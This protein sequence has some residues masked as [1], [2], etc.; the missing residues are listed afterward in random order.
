MKF[1]DG[2]MVPIQG[3]RSILFQCMNDDQRLLTKIY[4]I[5]SLKSNISI[6]SQM[7]KE[8]NKVELAG[9]FFKMFNGNE[10]C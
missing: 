8:G 5:P 4:Y 7:T 9:L 3:I 1:D 2:S 10:P 6:F